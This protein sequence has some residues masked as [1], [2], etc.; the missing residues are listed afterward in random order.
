M[1][2]SAETMPA[3]GLASSAKAAILAELSKP[4]RNN[5]SIQF[6][7]CTPDRNATVVV[8]N[9]RV[10]LLK[11]RGESA[12]SK[13][14][15]VLSSKYAIGDTAMSSTVPVRMLGVAPHIPWLRTYNTRPGYLPGL[16]T[17]CFALLSAPPQFRVP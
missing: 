13:R 11:D 1:V 16:Q 7:Q 4:T 9:G 15:W 12:G 3:P 2:L 5:V 8:T 10:T 17:Y 6:A 14:A